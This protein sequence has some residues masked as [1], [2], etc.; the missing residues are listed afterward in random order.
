MPCAPSL[1]LL[2]VALAASA[3]DAAGQAEASLRRD[4]VLDGQPGAALPAR[5]VAVQ[6][7]A[8]QEADAVLRSR[9]RQGTV[10]LHARARCR[11]ERA[12]A[13]RLEIRPARRAGRRVAVEDRAAH[14]RAPTTAIAAKEDSPARAHP[15]VRGRQV[16]AVASA[17]ARHLALGDKIAGREVALRDADVHLVRT[18]ARSDTVIPNPHTGRVQM[19]VASS[20][21]AGVGSWQTLRA[22]RVRRL[23]KRAFGEEPGR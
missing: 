7:P 20:G 5:W 16:E 3:P 14:R 1:A 17:T 10:V 11:R 12:A 21:A 15:R 8:G 18:R 4:A 23:P 2:A 13:Y 22:Q 9:R 6:D 19:I